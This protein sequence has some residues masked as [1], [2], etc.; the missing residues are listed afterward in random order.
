MGRV[1]LLLFLIALVVIIVG[2]IAHS[3][4]RRARLKRL[5]AKY[6]VRPGAARVAA[7]QDVSDSD[8]PRA[9]LVALLARPRELDAAALRSAVERAWGVRFPVEPADAVDFVVGDPPMFMVRHSGRMFVVHDQA[10]PY[11]DDSAAAAQQVRELRT[12]KAVADHQAWLSMD[13][14]LDQT[15]GD[16]EADQRL[17]CRVMAE[18]ADDDFLALFDPA[19]G[20][21]VVFDEQVRQT[22]RGED[23]MSALRGPATAPP[24]LTV[25]GDDPRMQAAVAEARRRWPEFVAAFEQRRPEQA[26]SVKAPFTRGGD[27]EFM[28][29]VV[30]A[31][32]GGFVYGALGNQPVG[33]PGL[34][35]GDRVRVREA[36][37]NDWIYVTDDQPVGGFTLDVVGGEGRDGR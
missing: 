34:N 3:I 11:F 8:G 26:F 9:S 1:R 24:V 13:R 17:I 31:I 18:L 7:V 16:A 29:V 21:V 19:G 36:D 14:M 37:L 4:Q 5:R 2:G 15:C 28:W 20:R 27:T 6:A 30:D 22:L 23:P 35:E 10:R 25:D 32:E 12:R 33:L